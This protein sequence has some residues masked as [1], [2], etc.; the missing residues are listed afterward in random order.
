LLRSETI[1]NPPGVLAAQAEKLRASGRL[2]ESEIIFRKILQLDS[3]NFDAWQGLSRIAQSVGRIDDAIGC[4]TRAYA[5][6]PTAG[7]ETKINKLAKKYSPK[8]RAKLYQQIALFQVDVGNSLAALQS[9]RKSINLD[10]TNKT[11]FFLFS[12]LLMDVRFTSSVEPSLR[13]DLLSALLSNGADKQHMVHAVISALKNER[14]FN[15]LWQRLRH[16]MESED[17]DDDIECSA[18][19][20]QLLVGLL[21]GALITDWQMEIFLTAFRKWLLKKTVGHINDARSGAGC[22]EFLCALATQ[23]LGNEYIYNVTEVESHWLELLVDAVENQATEHVA[24]SSLAIIGSY[25]PLR[26]LRNADDLAGQHWPEPWDSLIELQ[27]REP[28]AEDSIKESLG[29][30]TDVQNE[31][32]KT[33]RKQY[34]EN[35]FPRWVDLPMVAQG[36]SLD[37]YIRR[38]F[39]AAVI[40]AMGQRSNPEILVAG[41]G[42]GL[43]PCLFARQFPKSRIQAVDLSRSSLAYGKRKADKL[44]LNNIEFLQGDILALGSLARKFDFINCYGVLHHTESIIESWRVLCG[45]LKPHGFMQIGLYSEIARQ[46]VSEVRSYIAEKGYSSTLGGMRMCRLDLAASDNPKLAPIVKSW[47]FYSASNFRDLAFHVY[48]KCITLRTLKEMLDELNL[49][50]IG[51]ELDYPD[52]KSLYHLEYPDDPTMKSLDNWGEFEKR[53]PNTFENCYK[54]W[55]QQKI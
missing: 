53:H 13:A 29:T 23:C 10:S 37:T 39:P 38:L 16:D 26:Q 43:I 54:F 30:I 22:D 21:C 11:S 6:R 9:I 52:S 15:A 55:V 7:L 17:I 35:P 51:F 42:T 40:A 48:E 1:S 19:N 12:R 32:S 31:I 27:I 5:I 36:D 41:C 49:E 46:S 4:L 24:G 44:G 2:Q 45:L 50:F 18:L 3:K 33:V 47:S 25:M 34:E 20:D 8:E 28:I 14:S